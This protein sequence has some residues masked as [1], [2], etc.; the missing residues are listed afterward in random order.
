MKLL[1]N[2]TLGKQQ[3]ASALSRECRK[4]CESVGFCCQVP[5]NPA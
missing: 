2:I 3:K 1:Q 5:T 4:K